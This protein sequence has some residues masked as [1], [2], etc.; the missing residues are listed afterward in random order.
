MKKTF[1]M[2]LVAMLATVTVQAQP[3]HHGGQRHDMDP[4]KFIEMRVDRLDKELNLTPEQKTAITA[5]YTRQAD[6]MRAAKDRRDGSERPTREQM[7]ANHDQVKAE[8]EAVLTAEQ[9]AKFAQMK[10][11]RR[12]HHDRKGAPDQRKHGGCC[13]DDGGKKDG[14]KK[15]CCKKGEGKC[16]KKVE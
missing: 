5:I 12:G 9:K 11:E 6:Q 2:M 14:G 3:R 13:K 4:T 8:V 15:D 10:D 7:R 1:L 16:E